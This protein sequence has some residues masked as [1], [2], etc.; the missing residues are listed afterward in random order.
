MSLN[1]DLRHTQ[2]LQSMDLPTMDPEKPVD[3]GAAR[4]HSSNKEYKDLQD[5]SSGK[6]LWTENRKWKES[7]HLE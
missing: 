3:L 5:K 7:R 6:E 4:V 2:A 1:L